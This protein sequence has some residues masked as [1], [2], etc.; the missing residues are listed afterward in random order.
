MALHMAKNFSKYFRKYVNGGGIT[1]INFDIVKSGLN[2][3]RED[4][5][6]GEGFFIIS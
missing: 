6:K 1:I 3:A 2:S 4:A 5:T